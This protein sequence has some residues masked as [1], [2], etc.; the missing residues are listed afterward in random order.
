MSTKAK[1]QSICSNAAYYTHCNSW[2][3][4]HQWRRKEFLFGTAVTAKSWSSLLTLF[5]DS[6]FRNN[7]HS[8]MTPRFSTNLFHGAR[9]KRH[10]VGG[11]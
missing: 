5:A 6:D 8:H 1:Y 2:L 11:G 4:S 9:A 3:R 7:Q 10:S